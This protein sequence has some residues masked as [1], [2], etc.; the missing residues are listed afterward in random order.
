MLVIP[1]TILDVNKLARKR[2]ARAVPLHEADLVDDA[3]LGEL[4][5]VLRRRRPVRGEVALRCGDDRQTKT[6]GQS[7]RRPYEVV[8][9]DPVV[10]AV[11]SRHILVRPTSEVNELTRAKGGSVRAVDGAGES[12]GGGKETRSKDRGEH[13]CSERGRKEGKGECG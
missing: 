13:R 3:A 6:A 1:L 5:R 12:R 2:E 7:E 8:L 4:S 10:V 9:K 11:R